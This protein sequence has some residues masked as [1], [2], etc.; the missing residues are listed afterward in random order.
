MAVRHLSKAYAPLSGVVLAGGKSRRLGYDKRRLRLWGEEGPTLLEHSVQIIDQ[1][2]AET[3]VVLNDADAWPELTARVVSD[4]WPG[5]G[6]LGGIISALAAMR[7]EY[8]LC[9]AADMPLLNLDLLT[10]FCAEL[11]D[12]EALVPQ[13][14]DATTGKLYPEPLHAIYARQCYT[15]F[16][17]QLEAGNI[18]VHQALNTVTTRYLSPFFC[19]QFDAAGESFLN[20]NTAHDLARAMRQSPL[21]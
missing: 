9:V 21:S 17:A 2:C 12:Y 16:V 3:I 4:R 6:P 15:P 13:Q 10:A 19:A 18:A 8:A 11:R 20:I 14:Y 7:H 5:T 1:L